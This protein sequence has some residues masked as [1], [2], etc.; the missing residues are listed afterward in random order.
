MD[1]E[2]S[3]G[4]LGI[5]CDPS[6]PALENFPTEYHSNWQWWNIVMN[7]NPIVLDEA[8]MDLK[9]IVQVIDNFDRNHKLGLLFEA[10]VGKGK[11][12]VF[13]GN[14]DNCINEPEVGQ[15]LQSLIRYMNSEK[16]SPDI[17]LEAWQL[18]KILID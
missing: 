9:P 12:L 10:R 17:K 4:T 15:F 7:S 1:L 6:H 13:A 18:D 8:P 5:L 2:P 11:L 14:L 3:P 16:F